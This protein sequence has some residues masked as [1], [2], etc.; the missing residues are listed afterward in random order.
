M[1]F[2]VASQ[3]QEKRLVIKHKLNNFFITGGLIWYFFKCLVVWSLDKSIVFRV[4]CCVD[5]YC[6]IV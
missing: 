6:L 3:G 4:V 2:L 1:C 5:S